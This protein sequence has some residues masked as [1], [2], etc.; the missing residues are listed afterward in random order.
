M[1]S[2]WR[3]V[4]C[5]EMDGSITYK[6]GRVVIDSRV[7]AI[8]PVE[9]SL[10]QTAVLLIGQRLYCSSA[11]LFEMAQYGVSVMLCDW[12]GV[13]VAALHSWTDLP[14]TVTQRQLAQSQLSAPRR[15]NAW[16]RLV[17]AKIRGQAACL[18]AL[19]RKEEES[20][21]DWQRQ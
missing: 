19:K 8:K 15:K 21:E 6:R 11:A 20:S 3:V 17:Q 2:A 13:P 14:T 7:A 12:R 10:A 16:A 1:Q 4:D 18:D 9:V 5:T